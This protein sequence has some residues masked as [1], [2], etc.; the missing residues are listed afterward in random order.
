M[1]RHVQI[2]SVGILFGFV[3]F[4]FLGCFGTR[5]TEKGQCENDGNPCT[6]DTCE[7]GATLHVFAPEGSLCSVGENS[8]KCN[9]TG[10]CALACET[11]PTSCRCAVDTDCPPKEECAEWKCNIAAAKCERMVANEGLPA[12]AQTNGDCK[13]VVCQGGEYALIVDGTD[14]PP[15]G[16]ECT[17]NLCDGDGEVTIVPAELGTNCI[18]GT[19][20]GKGMCVDCLSAMD[21][22]TCGGA[23]C[24]VKLCNGQASEESSDCKSGFAADGVCCDTACTGVCKSC[25]VMGTVGSCS[26]I[27]YYQPDPSYVP[28]G[29]GSPVSCDP[30]LAGAFCDGN[31]QCKKTS[32]T[33]CQTGTQCLSGMCNP[34]LKCLGAPGEFCI[35]GSECV[36]GTCMMGN[37]K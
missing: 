7:S 12:G 16:E 2:T 29:G 37:C 3:A 35:A 13:Q 1:A 4:S 9:D 22:T 26:N 17:V 31:G 15:P 5:T 33:A 32:G 21:W 19:C 30:P 23:N 34:N 28:E 11:D 10:R 14:S 8:G 25:N 6:I 24:P 36:S 27:P 18:S 20:N